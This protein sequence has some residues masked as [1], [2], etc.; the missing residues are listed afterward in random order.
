MGAR[1]LWRWPAD[2]PTDIHDKPHTTGERSH[3]C[4]AKRIG[5]GG[6]HVSLPPPSGLPW[7]YSAPPGKAFP[8]GSWGLIIG[9]ISPLTGHLGLPDTTSLLSGKIGEG[10]GY[11]WLEKLSVNGADPII[12]V[13]ERLVPRLLQRKVIQLR[14]SHHLTGCRFLRGRW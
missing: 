8:D 13:F 4:P 2:L 5:P 6:V 9:L 7:E 1:A 3:E 10:E 12:R 14:R 11:V